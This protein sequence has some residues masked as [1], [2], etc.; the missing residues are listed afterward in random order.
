M[1]IITVFGKNV[2]YLS[3]NLS[4]KALETIGEET[5]KNTD[6]S[7]CVKIEYVNDDGQTSKESVDENY[8]KGEYHDLLVDSVDVAE[9]LVEGAEKALD[10]L[11]A[12]GIIKWSSDIYT[13]VYKG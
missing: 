8:Y 9:N 5:S 1:K 10:F 7:K 3:H 12:N 13:F 2:G 4:E 11:E 6:L